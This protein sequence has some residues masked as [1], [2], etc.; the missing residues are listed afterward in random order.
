MKLICLV[1]IFI[2][3]SK[4][5]KCHALTMEGGGTKGAYEAGAL[6]G[7]AYNLPPEERSWE[8]I[9]GMS[10]GSITAIGIA[11]Y[12]P[13]QE[14]EAAEF[15]KTKWTQIEVSDIF[16]NWPLS[17]IQGLFEESGLFDT[18]PERDFIAAIANGKNIQLMIHCSITLLMMILN[19]C[20]SRKNKML[21]WQ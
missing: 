19:K 20:T 21:R 3:I 1:A 11:I 12:P 16:K 8:V 18:S 10:V 15:I 2:L 6:Y 5:K 14:K 17:I 13:G 4:Q 9:S 7:L